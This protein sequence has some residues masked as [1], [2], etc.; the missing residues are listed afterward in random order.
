MAMTLKGLKR[1]LFN[2]GRQA[3]KSQVQLSFTFELQLSIY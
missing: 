1:Q 2:I 3:L